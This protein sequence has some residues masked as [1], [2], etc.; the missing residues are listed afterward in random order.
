MTGA[1]PLVAIVGRPNVGKST[2]F[3]RLIGAR[4][5]I[6]E[7]RPGVTRDR[8]YGV[9]EWTGRHFLVVDT[10]GL[11]PTED[12]DLP[13]HVAE[14][15]EIAVAEADLVVYVVDAR[16]GLS[17]TDYELAAR[18][19]ASG[20]PVL[21]AA[22]K[23]D[24]PK[25][26]GEALVA[27]ELG[28]GDAL[29][30]SAAH[31]RGVGELCDAIVDLL[32]VVEAAPTLVPDGMR[33]AFVGRP[34]VGKSTL[35][36][37][38]LREPR[39]VVDD[40]PGT[41]HD[42]VDLAFTFRGR[43]MVLVDTAGL[44]RRRQ[45]A[46]AMEKLAAIKSIRAIERSDVVVLV[47]DAGEG[48]TD[49]DQRIANMAFERG[50]GVVVAL[51]KWDTVRSNG[52]LAAERARSAEQKLAFLERPRIVKTSVVG[53]GRDR[54]E[55]RGRNL[56]AVLEACQ[57][58]YGALCR[59][60]RTA[61]LNRELEAAVAAMTPPSHRNRRVKLL[62]A[63]QADTKPPLVVVTAN[64]GRCLSPAY[65]RYLLRRFRK[66]WNLWGVP[67]RLVVRA[68]DRTNRERRAGRR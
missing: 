4:R 47:V 52:K 19:R 31:G 34:N 8:L 67:V 38:L 49:Q 54:G 42:A 57:I 18:L 15:V 61:D 48:V 29:P 12:V 60:V 13:G 37:T 14:Q 17:G 32:P 20:K 68:R 64:M 62:Y 58:T 28:L 1:A 22:N 66:R 65:E 21:V 33:I 26:E 30:I 23:A 43:P 41:T 9:A 27:A 50:K 6:V 10:A 2:L 35:I 7:D 51:H 24:G 59:R 25:I 53:E 5:A 63:T 11:G 3:N 16:A 55:G 46:R 40:R 56:E 36:N 39:V 44:R 45:V